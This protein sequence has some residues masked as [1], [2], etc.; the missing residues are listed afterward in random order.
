MNIWQK[1][2]G[3]KTEADKPPIPKPPIPPVVES[4]A[5]G[6]FR[7]NT[8]REFQYEQGHRI[9]LDGGAPSKV[10]N[11]E[12][13]S[14]IDFGCPDCKVYKPIRIFNSKEYVCPNCNVQWQVET[15]INSIQFRQS[16][17]DGSSITFFIS[18]CPECKTHFSYYRNVTSS[19]SCSSYYC[20]KCKSR[21]D[22]QA[23]LY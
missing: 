4:A 10:S 15:G 6:I 18:H 16:Y 22:S 12:P 19:G 7:D 1:I 21:D 8:G 14:E 20:R 13:P 5:P 23:M 11:D 3:G 9:Y 17:N 2:F